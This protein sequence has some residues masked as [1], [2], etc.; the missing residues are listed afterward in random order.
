MKR[1]KTKT[2]QG[3]RAGGCPLNR[4]S[5]NKKGKRKRHIEVLG[6]PWIR[7]VSTSAGQEV[8]RNSG[9]KTGC[10]YLRPRKENTGKH[11]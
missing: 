9:G 8:A 3:K 7:K 4:G 5:G 10:V 2:L 6:P 11:G 1:G